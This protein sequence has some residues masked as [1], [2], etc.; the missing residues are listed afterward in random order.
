MSTNVAQKLECSPAYDKLKVK[1]IDNSENIRS[2][3]D[4]SHSRKREKRSEIRI[5]SDLDLSQVTKNLFPDESTHKTT[6][7]PIK[8]CFMNFLNDTQMMQS[9]YYQT[10]SEI[11]KHN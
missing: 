6:N 7:K 10:I 4:K 5:K 2:T 9:I 3:C 1:R 11:L 8:I